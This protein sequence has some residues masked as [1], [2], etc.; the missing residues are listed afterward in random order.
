MFGC[1]YLTTMVYLKE[2]NKIRFSIINFGSLVIGLSLIFIDLKI[3]VI[4]KKVFFFIYIILFLELFSY[5]TIKL[6]LIKD[7]TLKDRIKN[8]TTNDISKYTPDLRSDY[9]PNKFHK[10]VNPFLIQ[11]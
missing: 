7:L 6:L 5:F 4:A 9:K 1:G 11:I 10:E 8:V 3:K 2:I